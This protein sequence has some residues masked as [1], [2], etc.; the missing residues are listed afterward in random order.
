[1]SPPTLGIVDTTFARVDMAQ[2]TRETIDEYLT[3]HDEELSIVRRTVPGI[4][5]LPVGAKRLISQA[6]CDLVMA[7][8]QVGPEEIDKQC[9]HEATLGIQQAQIATD[10]H[11]LE[12]FVHTDEAEDPG[13]LR[14]LA[15]NRAREH[16]LNAM[17]LLFEPDRLRELAGTGQR[18]GYHD[19]GPIEV[20]ADP[21]KEDA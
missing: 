1:M 6:G 3:D 13:R 11:V 16:A 20:P 17:W 14:W 10:T 21:P 19:E 4:K 18:E 5:D 7:L 9:A 8:G 2:A 15:E 12:V